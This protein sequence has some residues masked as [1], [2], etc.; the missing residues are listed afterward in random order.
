MYVDYGRYIVGQCRQENLVQCLSLPLYNR[1][2]MYYAVER[3]YVEIKRQTSKNDLINQ[4]IDDDGVLF[5]F[6]L[7]GPIAGSVSSKIFI[8]GMKEERKMKEKVGRQSH[9]N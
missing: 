2:S 4:V 3:V 9:D 5:A 7:L 1:L 8:Y 6:R